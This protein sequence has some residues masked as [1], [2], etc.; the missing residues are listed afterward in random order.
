MTQ[1]TISPPPFFHPKVTNDILENTYD[2]T[3]TYKI[4]KG[5]IMAGIELLQWNN[6]IKIYY[7]T[8]MKRNKEFNKLI[9]LLSY[10]L[11]DQQNDHWGPY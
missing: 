3:K 6:S 11:Y 8:I 4:I 1:H 2:A 10:A 5:N 7:E 9:T